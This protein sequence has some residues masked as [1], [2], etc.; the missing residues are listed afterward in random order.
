MKGNDFANFDNP[1]PAAS[2]PSA[3][4]DP[5]GTS[6]P[7]GNA[8]PFASNTAPATTAFDSSAFPPMQAS[9]NGF[10]AFPTNTFPA[11]TPMP[12]IRTSVPEPAPAPTPAQSAPEPVS[13]N[14][15]AFDDLVVTAP[16]P[17]TGNLSANPFDQHVSAPP[18][19]PN[20]HPHPQAPYPPN[21]N[22]AYPPQ[23]YAYPG[24]QQPPV[25][26]YQQHPAAPA[27]YGQPQYYPN[28]NVNPYMV[29]NPY[30]THPNQPAYGYAPNP[31]APP[32]QPPAQPLP[33]SP[34]VAAAPDPFSDMTGLAL[35]N[36]SKA[37]PPPTIRA[38]VPVRSLHRHMLIFVTACLLL[39]GFHT[40]TVARLPSSAR[41]VPFE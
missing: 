22:Y 4:F 24:Q 7:Q 32:N 35:N 13:K 28:P 36:L 39:V 1:S 9:F 20:A 30:P 41:D 2:N 34:P 12:F 16:P 26:Y 33:K 31:G 10:T 8:D 29:P 14:F 21:P 18:A 19:A 3:S 27:P 38:A 5:F 6:L 37:P 15:N 11:T 17:A 25:Q 40:N 23:M